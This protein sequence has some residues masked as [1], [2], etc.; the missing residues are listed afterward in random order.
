M[1]DL[2]TP[3]TDEMIKDLRA[4][5]MVTITG[6]IYTARDAAHKRLTDLISEGKELPLD[7]KGQIIY[8]AGP[9]P[10][11]PGCVIGSIGPTTSG[12]M[13]ADATALRDRCG[14]KGMIGKGQRNMS[15]RRAIVRN[16]CVYFA[17]T[18][19]AGALL[20]KHIT[21]CEIVAYEDL[22]CEAIRKLTV[23][24]LPAVVINDIYGADFYRKETLN[25][26]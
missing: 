9:T 24:H 22:G 12:R 7:M 23:D 18:G 10:E 6:T 26:I 25:N 4:G 21:G 19:G 2:H 13:D 11:K 5:D 1:K 20:R 15:V 17:A 3:L 8:Y 16:V 14:L